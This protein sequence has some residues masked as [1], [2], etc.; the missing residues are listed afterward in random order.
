MLE[1]REDQV[2]ELAQECVDVFRVKLRKQISLDEPDAAA[3]A[4]DDSLRHANLIT[5]QTAFERPGHRGWFVLPMGAFLGELV[6]KNAGGSWIPAEG[7]GL[8]LI[9]RNG[10]VEATL[11]PFDK[12]LKQDWTG[13]PDDLIAYVRLAGDALN[14][15]A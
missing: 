10:E 4:L 14:S 12:I 9:I 6:K 2:P 11:H 1:V 3:A 7:G 15:S 8:A 5:T 13:S